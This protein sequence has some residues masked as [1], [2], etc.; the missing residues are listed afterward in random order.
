MAKLLVTGGAG[1]IGRHAVRVLAERGHEVHAVARP[2]QELARAL[3]PA[4]V[5]HRTDLLDTGAQRRLL[6]YVRPTHLLHL[7]W[8]VAPGKFWT[9]LENLDWVGASLHLMRAFADSGGQ[10]WVGAGTCAE[11][12]WSESGEFSEFGTSLRPTSLY[13]ISKKALFEVQSSAAIQLGLQFCWGRIFHLYGPGEPSGRLVPSVV[14][15]LMSRREAPLGPGAQVRDFAHAEDVA[16]A[17]STLIESTIEGPVNIG[18]GQHASVSEV[19]ETIGRL[20]GRP[21]LLRFH[22]LPAALE[23]SVMVPVLDRL[24][25]T[26]FEPKWDLNRGLKDTIEYWKVVGPAPG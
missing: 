24:R 10:R 12:D 13:G 5:V 9:S 19:A 15:K 6:D 26:G 20:L 2:G 22:A 18:C 17:F 1:F 25:S 7:A 11:Y 16:S 21:N 23:P 14:L 4:V 8:Y 3:H